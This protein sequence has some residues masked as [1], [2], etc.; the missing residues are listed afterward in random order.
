MLKILDNSQKVKEQPSTSSSHRSKSRS[1]SAGRNSKTNE[2]EYT[3]EDYEI[4]Q[5][6]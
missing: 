2:T 5:R 3:K 1:K 6:F 4:V